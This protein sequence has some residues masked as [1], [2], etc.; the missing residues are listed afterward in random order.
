VVEQ[1]PGKDGALRVSNSLVP[2]S[3]GL[4]VLTRRDDGSLTLRPNLHHN[5]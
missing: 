3:V 5:V 1:R 4:L 2:D